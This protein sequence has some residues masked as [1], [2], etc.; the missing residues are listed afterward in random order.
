MIYQAVA[1][2][3]GHGDDRVIAGPLCG[4]QA[5]LLGGV[6]VIGSIEAI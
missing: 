2:R 4:F 5:G 1:R 3:A 6:V